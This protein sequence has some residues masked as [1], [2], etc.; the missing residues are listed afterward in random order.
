MLRIIGKELSYKFCPGKGGHNTRKI[1]WQVFLE[2]LGTSLPLTG[3]SWGLRARNAEKIS[4]MSSGGSGFGTPKSF[5][6]VLGTDRKHS[7]V[8]FR[9]LSEDFPDCP[10]DFLET[11][12][13]SGAGAPGPPGDIFQIFLA[14]RAQRARET[15]VRGGLAPNNFTCSNLFPTSFLPLLN[16][17]AR[18]T[19]WKP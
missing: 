5:Q 9:R 3:V 13:G 12:R 6:K 14:F 1:V 17:Q 15:P 11:C 19:I 2:D 8:T 7:S 4:K 16:R 10:R 18:T